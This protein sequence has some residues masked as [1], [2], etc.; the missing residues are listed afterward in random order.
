MANVVQGNLILFCLGEPGQITRQQIKDACRRW[1]PSYMMP[2]DVIVVEK[3]P[4][5]PSGKID[6]ATLETS[7]LNVR[8]HNVTGHQTDDDLETVVTEVA[9]IVFKHRIHVRRSLSQEG[10]DSLSA[11]DFASLLRSKGFNIGVVEI[12]SAHNIAELCSTLRSR[13]NS[14]KQDNFAFLDTFH[15]L[16]AAVMKMPESHGFHSQIADILPCTPLQSSMLV[17]TS[18]NAQAYCN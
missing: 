2:N 18:L 13:R 11:I 7:Y 4:R 12:L 15:D 9:S 1:L 5:L 10:L 16:R 8:D 14:S 17:E 6:R 3:L